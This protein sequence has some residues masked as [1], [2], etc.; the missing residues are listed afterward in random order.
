MNKDTP[1]YKIKANKDQL[2]RLG[3]SY[4]ITGL[5]GVLKSKYP[6]G[7]YCLEVE[8]EVDGFKFTNSFNIPKSFL[9]KI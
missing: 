6:T 4:D 1:K 7:W 8:H 2:E 3:I 9:K 5:I